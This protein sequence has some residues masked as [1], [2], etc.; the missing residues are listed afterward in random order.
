MY[1]LFL[2]DHC[3][4]TEYQL[5][6]A[7]AWGEAGAVISVDCCDDINASVFDF[8]YGVAGVFLDSQK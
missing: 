7:G 6:E 2:G 5:S 4:R 8:V 1:L 3:I